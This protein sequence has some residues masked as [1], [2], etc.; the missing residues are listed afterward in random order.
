MWPEWPGGW[1][2]NPGAGWRDCVQPVATRGQ[3]V[4]AWSYRRGFPLGRGA[5]GPLAH[6]RSRW[7]QIVRDLGR[8]RRTLP[9]LESVGAVR[10]HA[11]LR[12]ALGAGV[13]QVLV[14]CW[15]AGGVHPERQ[16]AGQDARPGM[17][18]S[19]PRME[20]VPWALGG[21]VHPRPWMPDKTGVWHRK[22]GQEGRGPWVPLRGETS[23]LLHRRGS[24]RPGVRSPE[25]G[26]R[27]P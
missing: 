10:A 1:P 24:W 3:R 27:A 21:L 25:Q 18:A 26:V 13:G 23:V 8:G 20:G 22:E 9:G 2:C 6:G 11:R 16:E 7:R 5:M 14:H 17:P 4:L 12:S 15:W 19:A